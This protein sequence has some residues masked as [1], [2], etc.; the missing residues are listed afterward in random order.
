[1]EALLLE[2]VRPHLGEA[3]GI[4]DLRLEVAQVHPTGKYDAI[5][6]NF[7]NLAETITVIFY[8]IGNLQQELA[9]PLLGEEDH[10][11]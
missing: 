2:L 5:T 11:L 7:L 8:V 3:N 6:Q 10:L 9:R 1:M 4:K